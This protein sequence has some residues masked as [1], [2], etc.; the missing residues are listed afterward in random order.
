ME[1]ISSTTKPGGISWITT[2]V[3]ASSVL[4]LT[5][6]GMGAFTAP[7]TSEAA[8]SLALQ[9]EMSQTIKDT[10]AETLTQAPG[11]EVPKIQGVD[12]IGPVDGYVVQIRF[13]GTVENG[14]PVADNVRAEAAA[15]MRALFNGD[16]PI[17]AVGLTVT[18][19]VA[20]PFGAPLETVVLKCTLNQASTDGINWNNISDDE[21]FETMDHVWWHASINN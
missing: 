15:I 19:P 3:I 5:L 9:P 1:T 12:I 10:I 11:R 13:A 4:I 16:A 2:A 7:P 21:L 17:N 6:L 20:Q 14:Q 18:C 8:T